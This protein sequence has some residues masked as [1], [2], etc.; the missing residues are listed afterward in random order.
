[1]IGNRLS[2]RILCQQEV[3]AVKT[4]IVREVYIGR[5]INNDEYIKHLMVLPRP[6]SVVPM[7]L[8]VGGFLAD[9]YT[10]LSH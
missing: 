1:M 4:V 3:F 5:G 2:T 6:F 8:T 9:I 7:G 10:L